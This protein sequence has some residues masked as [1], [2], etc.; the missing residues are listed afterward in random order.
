MKTVEIKRPYPAKVSALALYISAIMGALIFISILGQQSFRVEALRVRIGI[1]PAVSGYTT[2]D[3]PPL[4]TIMAKTHATPIRIFIR[5]DRI[6]LQSAQKMM[7]NKQEHTGLMQ[8]ITGS[9]RTAAIL[10]GLKILFL[11][12]AGGAF[13]VFLW[14]R[15]IDLRH[16]QGA[17]AASLT[18]GL[19][20]LGTY[21]TYDINKFKNP[22]FDGLKVAPWVISMA[23][24][25][26]GK[27]D[28]LNNKMETIA[29][30]VSQLFNQIDEL[31]T[32]DQDKEGLVKVLHVSDIHNNPAAL[33]YIQ[34]IAGVF[35]VDL[36]IDTGD[37]TD[38]G[39]P[40]EG[41]LLERLAGL[42]V[43]YLYIPGNHDSPETANKMKSIPEV[44]VLN[45]STVTVKNMRIAGFPDPSSDT[46][47]IEPPPLNMIPHL[48]GEIEKALLAQPDKP[49]ILALHNHRIAQLLIG[50]APVIL[51][52]H[53]HRL[54]VKEISETILIDAGSSGAA[55]L[56]RLQGD[57]TPYT[58]VLQYY[59]PEGRQM[60]LLAADTITVK[61]LD[62][63]FQ[64][65]RHIFKASR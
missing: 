35:K 37:I 63:G 8:K 30:N 31:Q 2:V 24:Q 47:D 60:K 59:A 57:R 38:Y 9:F 11:S 6:D 29:D 25:S 44:T 52:G 51:Y 15:N 39:T 16:L 46:S 49:D 34:R 17:L 5:L 7:D 1:Q 56:R 18:I 10:F 64:V 4:A 58:V 27:I 61:N 48:A 12:A 53:D 28:T 13:G 21:T 36:I 19:F 32:Y 43:P 20:F 41:L 54:A 40:L 14:Q 22:E 50:K 45:G 65:E 33:T 42:K 3:I 23:G 62:S 26:L 55:G